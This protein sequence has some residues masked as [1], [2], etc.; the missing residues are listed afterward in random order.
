MLVLIAL[1]AHGGLA[2]WVD[3]LHGPKRTGGS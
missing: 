2:G 3:R 1:Y